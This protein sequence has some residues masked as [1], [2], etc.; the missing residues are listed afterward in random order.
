MNYGWRKSHDHV[1]DMFL[2]TAPSPLAKDA[3]AS[4]V[5][6]STG[7]GLFGSLP[8]YPERGLTVQT[9]GLL[10]YLPILWVI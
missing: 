7:G 1:E 6:P 10:F 9:Y 2:G 8:L 5:A 3:A 4:G